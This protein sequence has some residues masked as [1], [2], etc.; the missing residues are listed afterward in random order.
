MVAAQ[1]PIPSGMVLAHGRNVGANFYDSAWGARAAGGPFERRVESRY[2]D[3]AEA[4]QLLF[5]IG[6]RTVLH[7]RLSVGEID[8]RGG[9]RWLQTCA[10]DE[11]TGCSERVAVERP[12]SP[13][14]VALFR[15]RICAY[16]KIVLRFK[17]QNGVV[18]SRPSTTMTGQTGSLRH[19]FLK[20]LTC[21]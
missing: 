10:A 15:I 13:V 1:Q 9:L 2:V 4:T 16:R 11:D 14:F 6:I 3:D 5:G 21:L 19:E 18:H 12:R 7:A 20:N 8:A 17:N